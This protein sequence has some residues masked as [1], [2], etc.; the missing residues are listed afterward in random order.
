MQQRNCQSSQR[1]FFISLFFLFRRRQGI[2]FLKNKLY[3]IPTKPESIIT[4]FAG[5]CLCRWMCFFFFHSM[6]LK[7][8]SWCRDINKLLSF[9]PFS[10]FYSAH[11]DSVYSWENIFRWN[12]MPLLNFI[13]CRV[14]VC[15]RTM[16]V[17]WM[18]IKCMKWPNNNWNDFN[19][20]IS[21]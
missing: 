15:A 18:Q 16:I 19:L 6:R 13:H 14:C 4:S 9:S 3:Y 11:F 8:I 20:F 17:G 21:F 2:C 12:S 1:F 5:R 7:W 10:D